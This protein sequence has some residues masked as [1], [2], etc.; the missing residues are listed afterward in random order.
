M[1]YLKTEDLCHKS[2][3]RRNSQQTH[4]RHFV[5]SFLSRAV[6]RAQHVTPPLGHIIVRLR[7]RRPNDVVRGEGWGG[8]GLV[9]RKAKS[10]SQDL[11]KAGTPQL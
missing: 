9:W 11:N 5:E 2:L 4:L 7:P 8:V 3:S 10:R 1:T 6:S